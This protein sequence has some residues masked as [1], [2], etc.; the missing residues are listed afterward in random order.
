MIYLV[1]VTYKMD[2]AAQHGLKKWC[3][4]ILKNNNEWNNFAYERHKRMLGEALAEQ[5]ATD[6]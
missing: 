4:T 3:A 1:I 6:V 2:V 5:W